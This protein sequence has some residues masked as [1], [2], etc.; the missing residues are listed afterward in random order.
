LLSHKK[1]PQDDNDHLSFSITKKVINDENYEELVMKRGFDYAKSDFESSSEKKDKKNK[2]PKRSAENSKK[3][4]NGSVAVNKRVHQ[5]SPYVI[6]L[7][8]EPEKIFESKTKSKLEPADN[9]GETW[10]KEVA[11]LRKTASNGYKSKIKR[12]DVNFLQKR[13]K[14]FF[15]RKSKDPIIF[16]NLPGQALKMLKTAILAAARWI[17]EFILSIPLGFL[18]F[19][20]V[21]LKLVERAHMLFVAAS[22]LFSR[23]VYISIEWFF[24]TLISI[25]KALIVIPIKL[26]TLFF[27]ILYRLINSFGL[28]ILAVSGATYEMIKNFGRTFANPPQHFYRKVFAALAFSAVLVGGVKVLSTA[29]NEIRTIRGNVLGATKEGFTALSGMD[30]AGV[31]QGQALAGTDGLTEAEYQFSQA[32]ENIDSLNV[33]LRGIIKLTPQGKDGLNVIQAGEDIAAAGKYISQALAPLLGGEEG[34]ANAIDIVKNLSYSLDLALPHIMRARSS[35][36]GI[37]VKSLPEEYQAKFAK[38]L[39]LLPIVESAV[40]D[41]NSLADALIDVMGGNGMRKYVVLFQNNNELRP[42]GGFI[43]SLALAEVD[44]G[45]IKSIN[46]PG[47]GSYDFQ[48][49]LT[50][51]VASPKPLWLIN[52]H[53]QLQDANWYPDWPT[54]AEKVAWFLEKSGQSSVDGVIA[55]QATTLQKLLR[56][57][58]PIEFPE[59]SITLNAQNIL[60]EIQT[61]VEVNYDKE[62]NA[63]KKYLAELTP[64]VLDRI[65]SSN[66]KELFGI[67]SLLKDEIEQKNI[68]PYFRN[69]DINQEFL[70]RKWEPNIV[71]SEMDYLSV[72]HANIGGGKTDGVIDESWDSEITISSEGSIMADLT[73]VRRHTGNP[74]VEFESWNNVDFAR[75]YVPEGSEL[76]SAEGFK[77]PAAA[78]YEQPEAY[79]HPDKDLEQIQGKVLIDEKSNTRINN[80]FGKTVFGNWIQAEPGNIAIARIKYKLPFKVHPFDILNPKDKSG[81]SLLIQKQAGARVIPY[82][83]Q[84]RYPIEWEVKWSQVAGGDGKISVLG[85]GLTMFEGTLARD[86]GY[87]ILFGEGGE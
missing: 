37:D 68:L 46:V 26:I 49:S 17:F 56:V 10:L 6:R 45:E 80:E 62:E 51:H 83:I 77:P 3:T 50:E 69:Q 61:A 33:V 34:E 47:G 27:L 73:I 72:I 30:L 4:N 48:G 58:G 57:L 13:S 9:A 85:P 12:V 41:F 52:P 7:A 42:A 20:Q 78:L 28:A 87:A 60:Q 53:W 19:L 23:G 24:V 39:A 71:P 2:M 84:I 25:A 16:A 40:L 18:L 14:K 22:R 31:G 81:Y 74:A 76:I 82:S 70:D 63:P 43:G 67:M 5:R 15:A 8:G 35:L 55:L 32:R 66:S 21:V 79:Y 75:A 86:T 11:R 36:A 54:S 1:N 38:G 59:Y 65:L 44:D 29:P 64:R